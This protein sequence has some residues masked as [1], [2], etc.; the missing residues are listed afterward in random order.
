MKLS[1]HRLLNNS[2]RLQTFPIRLS[3]LKYAIKR[4]EYW[5]SSTTGSQMEETSDSW[6]TCLRQHQAA[7]STFPGGPTQ[8][9]IQMEIQ[10][11]LWLRMQYF[12]PSTPISSILPWT[13]KNIV[14]SA[15]HVP[16]AMLLVLIP[17]L[18]PFAS[19]RISN[20]NLLPGPPSETIS[21]RYPNKTLI[22][23]AQT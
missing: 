15:V 14:M 23:S 21:P 10:W 11:G 17:T 7:T 8:G 5:V 3:L 19:L 9:G 2:K 18:I 22:T 20:G 12:F 13:H 16:E 6:T 1:K 4:P